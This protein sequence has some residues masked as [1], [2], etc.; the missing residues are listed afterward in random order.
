LIAIAL[1][2]SATAG[3]S[4]AGELPE[5]AKVLDPDVVLYSWPYPT[6][7]PDGQWVAYIS[8]GYVCVCN[9]DEPAPHR[10]AEVPHTWTWVA[11]QPENTDADGDLENLIHGKSREEIVA[12]M[13]KVTDTAFGLY[14]TSD[15][16]GFVYSLQ[17]YDLKTS[18]PGRAPKTI[19]DVWYVTVDG[20]TTKLAHTDSDTPTR[21]I[22]AGILTRDHRFLVNSGYERPLIWDVAT[23][24][25]RAT[26]FVSMTPSSTSG[27]WIC[28]EK[29]TGQLVIV[30]ENFEIIRRVDEFLPRGERSF[31]REL[32]W[33][34]DEKYVIWKNQIGFDYYSNWE[35][36]RVDLDTNV[37]REL[38]GAYMD[39]IMT[40]TGHGGEFIRVGMDGKQRQWSGLAITG[41][42]VQLV[43]DGDGE[44]ANLW[45]LDGQL[46]ETFLKISAMPPRSRVVF[47][48]DFG[49]FTIVLPRK[50]A[51]AGLIYHLMDRKH[52][53]W[54]MPG[55]DN[56]EYSSPYDVVG[57]GND[58]KT[59]IAYDNK[60]LFA[61]PVLAIQTAENEV[62]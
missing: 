52:H 43:P 19:A 20:E 46:G 15:S 60:Q 30:D 18:A 14:W 11:V 27:R 59:I 23:N 22:S 26:P 32:I 17:C 48:P 49:L 24:K 37:R 56:G 4:L 45:A 58:G 44:T 31:G 38:R 51:P 33:S 42:H 5:G 53:L 13:A 34:P 47:S 57:F 8:K 1:L 54:R 50:A 55:K 28:I 7:S 40:F 3:S 62:K 2:V 29:D 9:I 12:A 35:G 41:A 61:I 6:V 16:K 10:V 21:G 39:E 25:P 36:R